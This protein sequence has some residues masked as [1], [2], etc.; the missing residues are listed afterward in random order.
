MVDKK[1]TFIEFIGTFLMVIVGCSSILI[2]RGNVVVVALSFGIMQALLT[3]VWG[4]DY[5]AAVSVARAGMEQISLKRAA[6]L[7]ACQ[8]LGALGACL[9]IKILASEFGLI[10]KT[11]LGNMANGYHLQSRL[12]ISCLQAI[13]IEIG[14]TFIYVLVVLKVNE[15][16]TSKLKS[17]LWI[18]LT[19]AAVHYIG[20]PLTGCGVNPARSFGVAVVLGGDALQQLWVF[21][22]A[23]SIGAGMAA[24][25]EEG[26]QKAGNN[27]GNNLE[28]K[29]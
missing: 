16:G 24:L 25:V 5:N 23:P 13:L 29:E 20:I 14:L 10:D 19:L 2:S 3:Y 17:A 21:F 9:I 7:I 28:N 6:L 15:H 26:G 1:R 4:G 8:G 11:I 12:G 22:L 27:Q 18:G